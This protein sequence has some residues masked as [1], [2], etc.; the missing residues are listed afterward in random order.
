[1][2]DQNIPVE[3]SDYFARA[4]IALALASSQGDN[5]LVLVNDAFCRLTGYS[6]EDVVGRN[7]RFLQRDAENGE[8]KRQIHAF[9]QQDRQAN[10]RTSILNFRKDGKPFVNLLY[11]SKLR[12]QSG[13]VRFLFASQYDV[14]RS[15]PDRLAAYDSELGGTLARLSPALA[16]SGLALEGSLMVVANSAATIAQAKLTLADLNVADES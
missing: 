6:A 15:Q 7:C 4:T 2:D 16:E 9:L 13:E 12:G 5:P 14:S 3:I 1:M 10:V 8:A 11:M